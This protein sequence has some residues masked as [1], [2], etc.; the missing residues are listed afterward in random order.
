MIWKLHA[1]HLETCP[2]LS[3]PHFSPGEYFKGPRKFK[4]LSLESKQM[5]TKAEK[6]P[7][8]D[9][10]AR[11]PVFKKRQAKTTTLL[12]LRGGRGPQTTIPRSQVLL[13]R[14]E[15]PSLPG[16]PMGRGRL[17][18]GTALPTARPEEGQGQGLAARGAR[19]ARRGPRVP[20]LQ[21]PTPT[22]TPCGPARS[23]RRPAPNLTVSPGSGW[24]ALGE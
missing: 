6:K 3:L 13:P 12:Q 14:T 8:R 15:A 10:F 24:G 22:H 17:P 21:G 2:F 7:N 23:L 11:D 9:R 20:R 4:N 19:P 1:R 18:R 5:A 16:P